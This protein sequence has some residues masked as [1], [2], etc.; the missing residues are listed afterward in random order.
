ME[1]WLV[2]SDIF[3]FHPY[4]GKWSNL[5]HIFQMGWNHQPENLI[6]FTFLPMRYQSKK[7]R[8]STEDAIRFHEEAVPKSQPELP[9]VRRKYPNGRSNGLAV[10]EGTQPSWEGW[11]GGR[12]GVSA[13][14][15]PFRD[16]EWV[17]VTFLGER[18]VATWPL[19]T[20]PTYPTNLG[21]SSWVMLLESPGF[22]RILEFFFGEK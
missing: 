22:S 18:V 20:N 17:Q 11:S 12:W 8:K 7:G 9:S 10:L 21:W 2:V 14:S 3:Y 15:W 1:N 13:F 6:C 5:T 4:L 19:V 16:G